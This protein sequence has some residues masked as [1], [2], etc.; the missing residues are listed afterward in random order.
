MRWDTETSRQ[1]LLAT[2]AAHEVNVRFEA[3]TSYIGRALPHTVVE[4]LIQE[5][6]HS[7]R[8]KR[9]ICPMTKSLPV[10]KRKG[11]VPGEKPSTDFSS[12]ADG[13]ANSTQTQSSVSSTASTGQGS[14]E[15]PSTENPTI[16]SIHASDSVESNSKPSVRS[17][18]PV[19]QNQAVGTSYVQPAIPPGQI[20]L[21]KQGRDNLHRVHLFSSSKMPQPFL[22][23]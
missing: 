13:V 2:L 7:P 10:K 1:L 17:L 9:Y 3:C 20:L 15:V 11:V 23:R 16:T 22:D 5:A 4:W 8:R 19:T 18:L 21:Q 14:G 12:V 6:G